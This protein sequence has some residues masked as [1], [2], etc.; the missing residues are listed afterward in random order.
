[1]PTYEYKC[2]TCGNVT[3]IFHR[4][5]ESPPGTCEKCG[6]ALRKIFIGG[7]GIIFKGSGFYVND[8]KNSADGRAPSAGDSAD[9]AQ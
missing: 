3:E 1:M 7:A 6:S 9:T 8:Y 2:E 4:I 5:D